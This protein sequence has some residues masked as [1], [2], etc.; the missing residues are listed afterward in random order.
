[1]SSRKTATERFWEKVDKRGPNDCW[2]WMAGGLKSGHGRI[3]AYGRMILC[4]RFSWELVNGPIPEGEGYHGTCVLHKCDNPP[5]V[6]PAHLFLGTN[7]DNVQ[8]KVK[9]NRHQ[10]GITAGCVKLTEADVIAIRT[11]TRSA[12]ELAPIYGV[13][14]VQIRSI[15]RRVY[16]KHLP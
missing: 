7:N 9:K 15:R 5:C 12:R 14:D 2:E 8:D 10:K 6:N 3:R 13:C 1:M 4:H 11:D 16:W